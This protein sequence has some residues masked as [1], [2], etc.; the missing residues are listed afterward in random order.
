MIMTISASVWARTEDERLLRGAGC[1]SDDRCVPDSA[2]GIVV[3]SPHAAAD[4]VSISAVEALRRPGVL[5]VYTADD[6]AADGLGGLP[7][8]ATV[9]NRDGSEVFAPMRPVLA[10]QSVRH[11]GEPVAFV[12]ATER[13]LAV[14]A[15]EAIEVNYAIKPS[16]AGVE[17]AIADGAPSVWDETKG[18]RAF[19][20]ETGQEKDTDALFAKAAHITR[21]R[22][23]NNRL[24]PAA[25]EP[26]SA[27]AEYD[28]G[29]GRWTLH[30]SSQGGWLMRDLLASAALK[31]P[32]DRLRIV[33]PDVGGSFGS[34]TH[35]YPEHVLVCH[36]ARK[37][38][39]PVRWTADRTEAFLTDVHARDT[40]SY[41][42][43]ALDAEHRFTALRVRV[44]A[45]MGS[46]LS[47]FAPMIP[48]IIGTSV[49]PGVYRFGSAYARVTGVFTHTVPVDAY[50]GAGMPES[51]YVV[52]RLIDR[53]AAEIGLDRAALRKRNLI[54]QE[55]M[56]HTSILG[57]VYDS[58]RFDEMLESALRRADWNGFPDRRRSSLATGLR[59][60]IGICCYLGTT[61][62]P[63]MEMASVRFVDG[64]VVLNIGTQAS[65]QGHE[66]VYAALLAERLG[67]RKD[68]ILVK[69]GD[70]DLL[71]AGGGTGGSRSLYAGGAAIIEAATLV[72]ETGFALAA[73]AL[74]APRDTIEFRDGRYVVADTGREIG[75]LALASLK[76][77][78]GSSSSPL[79]R[80][81]SAKT[82][83]PTFPNGCHIAEVEV[84]PA[85]G[86]V[87]LLRYVGADDVGRV[88]NETLA[89]GQIHGG[90]AQGFGQ[91]I[92]ELAHYDGATGQLLAGSFM[93][94]ALPRAADLPDLEIAF[95]TIPCTT[96]PLGSKGAGEAGTL[97]S[98]PAIV[99]AVLDALAAD[100]VRDLETP[101]TA[102]RVWKSLRDGARS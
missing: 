89:L 35:P 51:I 83:T 43:L 36:A 85:T 17:S 55:A 7:C 87:S 84:D 72:I 71:P 62:G 61:G 8:V 54:S 75:L 99:S 60:G 6:L 16:C 26:R 39:R 81:A 32:S 45:N 19:D 88:L 41:A 79:N 2:F 12:V 67:L 46:H 102:E 77:E 93:D 56:P 53:A 11:V 49:L 80:V 25:M 28:S 15:A 9:P 68:A 27:C 14:D 98:L 58:G 34:K 96:N 92:L 78:D 5:A 10:S 30:T 57:S 31:V 100:G 95:T 13:H 44:I 48:T 40:V 23:V 42:E 52:E 86:A 65:G 76:D 94:Y 101:I 63:P 74:Q 33:T 3:R 50:R 97:A 69:Q 24:V 73:E 22:V 91:A 64:S 70:T 29:T 1:F 18:N 82:E 38:G 20:W 47:T 66:T 90:V 37:L 21:L 4:I 59:R